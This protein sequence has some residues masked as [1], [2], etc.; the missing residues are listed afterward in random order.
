MKLAALFHFATQYRRYAAALPDI[1]RVVEDAVR[2]GNSVALGPDG[3]ATV[4]E[5]DKVTLYRNGEPVF[6][7]SPGVMCTTARNSP[8]QPENRARH[9]TIPLVLPGYCQGS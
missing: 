2:A 5:G 4:T 1:R 3:V 6:W 9:A 8:V 7:A